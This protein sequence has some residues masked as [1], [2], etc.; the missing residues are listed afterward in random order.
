MLAL[1]GDST[2]NQFNNHYDV[3]SYKRIC[4]EIRIDPSSD[5]PF[6]LGKNH[7]LGRVNDEMQVDFKYPGWMKFSDEGGKVI[8]RDLISQIRPDMV[9]ATQY[10]WFSPK[11]AAG[12]TQAGLSCKKAS[13]QLMVLDS[14]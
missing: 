6:T 13:L 7:G 4:A 2:F 1:P 12:L 11:T 8:K 9:A 14:S 3:A 10:G 5:F